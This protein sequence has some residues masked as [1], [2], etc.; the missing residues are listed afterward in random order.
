MSTLE[1][2]IEQLENHV[3][4]REMGRQEPPLSLE[5]LKEIL[6]ELKECEMDLT[7][8]EFCADCESKDDR[9]AE[10]E[11]ELEQLRGKNEIS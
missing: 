9:I 2:I 11:E 5:S 6:I 7:P 8:P 10:L 4:A 3:T 1:G